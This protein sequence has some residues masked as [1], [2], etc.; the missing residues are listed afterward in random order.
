MKKK[1]LSK[2]I[3]KKKKKKKRER[4][5]K[6]TNTLENCQANKSIHFKMVTKTHKKNVH[7]MHNI[8]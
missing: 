8:I 5:M 2:F 3:N 7:T 4:E 6:N 1:N